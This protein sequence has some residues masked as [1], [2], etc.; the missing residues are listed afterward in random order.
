M[1]LRAYVLDDERLAVERLERMLRQSGRVDVVGR[2]TDPEEALA[3]L[4]SNTVDVLF[5]DIQM[6]GMT[7]FDVLREIATPIP[8][9]FTTAYDHYALEAFSANSIDYLLKP[10]EVARLNQSLDKLGRLTGPPV[11][12][13][14]LARELAS[15]LTSVRRLERIASRVGERVLVLDV[16]KV[17]YFMSRDK[18]TFAVSQ[19]QSHVVD[20]TLAELETRLDPRRF[21]R[22]HRAVLINLA[23]VKELYP[24]VD[25]ML[26]KV[27]D[28]GTELPVARDR[29][30]E[31][32]E[33][34]GI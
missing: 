32:R 19:A 33:R 5:I 7:G 27:K 23:S 14:L 1:I 11:D 24:G 16:S 8:V 34:L 20:H 30:R 28:D 26:V 31:L 3:F 17:S 13:R 10:I 22:I 29:V 2:S 15:R 9:I 4:N 18:L 21:A 12:A 6:P 25:G